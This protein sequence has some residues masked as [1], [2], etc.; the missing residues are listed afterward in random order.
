MQYSPVPLE[1][2]LVDI[3]LKDVAVC[4]I[5]TLFTRTAAGIWP[6]RLEFAGTC[7]RV[8]RFSKSVPGT[9]VS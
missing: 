7:G 3:F 1:Q 6:V 8:T 5:E 4:A 2:E 9:L